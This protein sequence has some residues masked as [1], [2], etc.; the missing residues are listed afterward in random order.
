MTSERKSAYNT[1]FESGGLTCKL[2]ALSFYSSSVQADSLVLRN[3]PERQAR[4]RRA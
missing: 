2:G 4:N 1:G 3:P